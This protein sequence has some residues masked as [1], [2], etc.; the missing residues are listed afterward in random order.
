MHKRRRAVSP[1]FNEGMNVFRTG[2]SHWMRAGVWKW[3]GTIRMNDNHLCPWNE[4]V[5][6]QDLSGENHMGVSELEVELSDESLK[7]V[8]GGLSLSDVTSMIESVAKIERHHE[9][10]YLPTRY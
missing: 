10:D 9:W 7:W 3:K 5:Q 6:G 8:H 1:S 2:M 4:T